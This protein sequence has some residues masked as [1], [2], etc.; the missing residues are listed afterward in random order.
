MFYLPTNLC[1][2]N[3]RENKK[4]CKTQTVTHAAKANQNLNLGLE[5]LGTKLRKE[6]RHSEERSHENSSYTDHCSQITKKRYNTGQQT[7]QLS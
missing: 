7:T 2:L 6:I 3:N 1:I 5:A 4:K